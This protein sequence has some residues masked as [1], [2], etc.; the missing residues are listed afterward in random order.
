[1]SPHN[2]D[3]GALEE[4]EPEADQQLVRPD[5]SKNTIH[6]LV[7]SYS[8]VPTPIAILDGTLTFLYRNDPLI[9]L[10]TTFGVARQSSLMDALGRFLDVSSARDLLHSLKDPARGYTWSG[11]IQL[12]T[13]KASNVLTKTKIIPFMPEEASGHPPLAWVAFFDDVTKERDSFLRGLFTSL[14]EASKLKDNDTGRHIERVNLYAEHMARAMYSRGD[15]AEVDIDFV[16]NIG[17]LAAMHDVGKIGTPDDILNKK[18]PL[19]EFEWSIMKEHTINGAF[20]LS[21]YPVPMAKE[22]AMSHHEWW[23][24]SGYPYNLVGSMIPLSA[25]IVALV[26]VY[27]ALRMKRSYKL[28]FDHARTSILIMADSGS[29]FDPAIVEVFKENKDAFEAIYNDYADLPD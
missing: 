19:D 25:R 23:N 1:M 21:S 26:D 2:D 16:D 17:F 12:K 5:Q 9:K 15:W 28:P 3:F 13:K 4:L 27:D 6:G 18:G 24:G 22:I 14:L 20:I 8:I 11:A 7:S 29:H 10:L